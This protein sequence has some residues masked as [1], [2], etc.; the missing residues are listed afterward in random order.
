[1]AEDGHHRVAAARLNGQNEIDADVTEFVSVDDEQTAELAAAR[2]AFERATG[3]VELGATRAESYAVLQRAIERFA[4]D[5]ALDELPRV[6]RRWE[7]LV[8]RPLW[9]K[10][11][12]REWSAAFPGDRTPIPSPASP[13]STCAPGSIGRKR[14]TAWHAVRGSARPW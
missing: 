2:L 1:L 9:A 14:W 6:A 7:R 5:Q 8:Y 3:L 12:D 11:R 10:I 13:R 4:R